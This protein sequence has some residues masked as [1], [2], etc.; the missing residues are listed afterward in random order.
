MQNKT[1][2]SCDKKIAYKIKTIEELNTIN[3]LTEKTW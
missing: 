2:T 1:K 3:A